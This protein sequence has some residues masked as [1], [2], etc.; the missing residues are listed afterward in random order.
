MYKC[1]RTERLAQQLEIYE[2][3]LIERRHLFVPS[4]SIADWHH[5]RCLAKE[6]L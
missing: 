5:S 6:L 3:G 2:L 1:R 4:V